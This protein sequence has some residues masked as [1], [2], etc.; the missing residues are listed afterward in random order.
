MDIIWGETTF[1]FTAIIG[2]AAALFGG[3][4]L[5]STA[6]LNSK[7][8]NIPDEIM[9]TWEHVCMLKID[10]IS[11][12]IEDQ[13][14]KLNDHLNLVQMKRS[15]GNEVLSPNMIFDQCLIIFVEIFVNYHLSK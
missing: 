4:T 6:F 15:S 7:S 12:P 2:C 14:E 11:F 10:K 1:L 13:M 3:V 9:N 8:K 5:H